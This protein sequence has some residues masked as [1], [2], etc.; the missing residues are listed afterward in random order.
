[1]NEPKKHTCYICLK[2]F[3]SVQELAEHVSKN[4]SKIKK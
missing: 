1:M 3:N 2:S 4:H